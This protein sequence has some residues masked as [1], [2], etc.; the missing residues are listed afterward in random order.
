MTERWNEERGDETLA[1]SGV[2]S[3]P[4]V[5]FVTISHIGN[6]LTG[7]T[8]IGLAGP[9]VG[10]ECV[11]SRSGSAVHAGSAGQAPLLLSL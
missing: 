11:L 5:S 9:E 6:E 7:W 10:G 1:G 2:D 4:V 8:K 3:R